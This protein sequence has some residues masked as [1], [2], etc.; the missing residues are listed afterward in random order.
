MF[1]IL[2]MTILFQ[3]RSVIRRYCLRGKTNT[4]IVTKLE[5]GYSQDALHL[6]ALEKW[7]ARFRAIRETVEDGE[8]PGRLPDNDLGDAVLTFHEK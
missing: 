8:S 7:T 4:K 1:I 3:Q 5:Q 2:R 6:R